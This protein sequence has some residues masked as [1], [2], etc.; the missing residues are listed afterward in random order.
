M[1]KITLLFLGILFLLA[2]CSQKVGVKLDPDFKP[3]VRVVANQD[4]PEIKVAEIVDAVTVADKNYPII[5]KD[6]REIAKLPRKYLKN[7]N[8]YNFRSGTLDHWKFTYLENSKV[9]E[10]EPK[11]YK[12][13]VTLLRQNPR[14][15]DKFRP[16]IRDDLA[17]IS[18]YFKD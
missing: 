12:V 14:D 8:Q 5:Q 6:G 17:N 1:R 10:A 18:V 7:A 4:Y 3:E 13:P 9:L 16:F 2:N 11:S 15:Y